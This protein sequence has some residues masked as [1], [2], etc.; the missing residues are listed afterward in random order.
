MMI[1]K[2]SGV[3]PG[4]E[5]K[6]PNPAQRAEGTIRSGD[7]VSISDEA[8]RAALAAKTAKLAQTSQDQNRAEKLREIKA[9]LN[10][11]E[12]DNPSDEMLGKIADKISDAFIG[13]AGGGRNT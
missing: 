11:G 9:R 1:D 5:P 3:G 6:K 7:N 10:N 12:Y 13:S 8:A 2:V 4:Y